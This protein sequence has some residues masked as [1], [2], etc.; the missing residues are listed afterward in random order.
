M[1]TYTI[2]ETAARSGFTASALRYYEGIGLLSPTTRTSA[3][4][5]VYDD[6][7]LDRLTFIAR[8]KELGCSLE[9]ITSLI[10]PW[11]TARCAPVQRRF[12]TLVTDKIH[13]AQR[14]VTELTALTTQ[15]RAAAARLGGPSVEGPCGEDCACLAAT[16]PGS[17][18]P[19]M[20]CTLAPD[21]IPD[22]L[23]SW[24]AVLAGASAPTT[25]PDGVTRVEF[26]E[27]SS[28]GEV[29]RLVAAEQRCCGFL[30]FT[31]TVHAGKTALEVRAPEGGSEMVSS[32]LG[33]GANA[34]HRQPT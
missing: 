20:A 18:Q 14:R 2:G 30:S 25:D 9:E 6:Q 12:H 8:A 17:G 10:G 34:P 24:H 33:L 7:A 19:P 5:R 21:E 22:R 1:G 15:L 4:Y 23:A 26:G 32:L 31:I 29:A 27:P 11:D 3:G 28:L 13:D 16:S